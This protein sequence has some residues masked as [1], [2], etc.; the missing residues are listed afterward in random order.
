LPPADASHD[1]DWT[2]VGRRLAAAR[3][4]RGLTQAQVAGR[5]G[6][7]ARAVWSWEHGEFA[8]TADRLPKLAKLYGITTRFLLYG[9]EDSSRELLALRHEIAHLQMQLDGVVEAVAQLSS[10]VSTGFEGLTEIVRSLAERAD[11]AE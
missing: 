6:V 7:K 4:A 11:A 3:R 2:A 9:I 10:S 5:V 1:V 8:P